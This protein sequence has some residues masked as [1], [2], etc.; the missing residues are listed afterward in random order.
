MFIICW[1]QGPPEKRSRAVRTLKVIHLFLGLLLILK[2]PPTSTWCAR[3]QENGAITVIGHTVDHWTQTQPDS[4]WLE[5]NVLEPWSGYWTFVQGHSC[6]WNA[7]INQFYV[8]SNIEIW[9]KSL[10]WYSFLFMAFGSGWFYWSNCVMRNQQCEQISFLVKIR[11]N[12]DSFS[13]SLLSAL[14]G[15]N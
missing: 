8:R 15:N 10:T 5:P 2:Q 12:C 3:H 11:K 7:L 6:F 14:V 13:F 1:K 4:T 9:H